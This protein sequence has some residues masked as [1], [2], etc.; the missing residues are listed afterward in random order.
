MSGGEHRTGWLRPG[1]A[2]PV[3]ALIAAAAPLF[4]VSSYLVAGELGLIAASAALSA[5]VFVAVLM[6][7][8][9]SHP[10]SRDAETGLPDRS[11]ALAQ[12]SVLTASGAIARR[13]AAA[14]AIGFE[15]AGESL[16]GEAWAGAMKTT[17]GRISKL[18]RQDDLVVRLDESTFGVILCNLRRADLQMVLRVAARLQGELSLPVDCD[19]TALFPTVSV[20]FCLPH[21]AP[22][23]DGAGMLTG[24]ERALAQARRETGGAIRAYA[25]DLGARDARDATAARDIREALDRGEIGPWFQPRVAAGNGELL[26][27]AVSPRW[28]RPGGEV[29]AGDALLPLTAE[30]GQR[31]KLLQTLLAR[32]LASLADWDASECRVPG[33]SLAVRLADLQHPSFVDRV[34]WEL[35]R[36][37][38]D[39]D[40]LTLD[41]L[42]SVAE[43]GAA[44]FALRNLDS[45]ARFGCGIGIVDFGPGFALLGEPGRWP[46]RR[47]A[48]AGALTSGI[49]RDSQRQNHLRAVTAMAD[50]LGI[51]VLAQGVETDAEVATLVELG[52]HQFQGPAL[53]PPL[54]GRAVPDWVAGRADRSEKA[55]DPAPDGATVRDPKT[56]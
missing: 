50:A 53:A 47:V 49:D 39:P 41:I 20:G 34:R 3:C 2:G 37:E 18:V 43:P 22:G 23:R 55:S 48:L 16:E 40:R 46:L 30:N 8:R 54:A 36:Y 14:L 45:L 19:G 38:L 6:R 32:S 15:A 13:R 10:V 7:W 35:D 42:E 31:A 33:L 29:L 28:E 12:L 25:G 21:R 44:E 1:V 27:L 24:A 52:C 4:A 11:A 26:E 9:R 56:A 17:A 51:A 5:L